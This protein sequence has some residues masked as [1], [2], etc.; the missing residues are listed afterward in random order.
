MTD[1]SAVTATSRAKL[2]RPAA[3]MRGF[4]RMVI[5]GPAGSGKTR[6]SLDIAE[7]LAQGNEIV[8]IDA[9]NG[10]MSAFADTHPYFE[11]LWEPPFDPR[12]LAETITD[13]SN[14]RAK[15]G[16]IIVDSGSRFWDGLGGTLDIANAPA[17][18]WRVADPA[19]Y[20][21]IQA[22]LRAPCHVIVCLRAKH[23]YEVSETSGKDGFN[24]KTVDKLGLGPIQSGDFEYEMYVVATMDMDHR[25]DITKSRCPA[26]DGKSFPAHHQGQ[27]AETYGEWLAAGEQLAS[28]ADVDGLIATMDRVPEE[29]ERARIK[30]QFVY[31][32][33]MPADLTEGQ[34]LGAVAWLKDNVPAESDVVASQSAAV[35]A[36][37]QFTLTSLGIPPMNEVA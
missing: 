35:L 28:Q 13:L 6:T 36:V 29:L 34:V 21:L 37:N 16:V 31:R 5:T 30:Q 7:E 2:V 14:G 23:I 32:F 26:L 17:G 19:Q 20:R 4:A 18:G 10:S 1:P 15:D 8:G 12:D 33:G 25:I 27:L 22:I 9:E 11:V 24:R 3:R